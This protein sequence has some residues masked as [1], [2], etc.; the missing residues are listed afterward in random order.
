M[1]AYAESDS[2]FHI[3]S[4]LGIS[5]GDWD[6]L[7]Q[8]SGLFDASGRIQRTM[9]VRKLQLQV[10]FREFE[11]SSSAGDRERPLWIRFLGLS[12]AGET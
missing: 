10:D 4:V 1:R 9:W 8:H 3:S 2:T 12:R 6:I 7:A 11:T 5:I